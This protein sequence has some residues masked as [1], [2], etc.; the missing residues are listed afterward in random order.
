MEFV[1]LLVVLILISSY[2][3]TLASLLTVEQFKLASKGGT[4]GFHGGSFVACLTVNNLKFEDYWHKPYYSYDDY[5]KALSGGGADA[6]IDEIPYIKM[7][8]GKYS[9]D[10]AM[11]SSEP[12][13]SGFAFV[14]ASSFFP[15]NLKI[16]L[17]HISI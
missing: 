13:T 3:A 12:K 2:T 11:I 8:L 1:W 9:A 17:I 5:A 7:F 6:I 10:Y 4:L 14:S 15:N 16:I